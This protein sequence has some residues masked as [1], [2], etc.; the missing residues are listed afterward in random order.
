MNRKNSLL[1][2][3]CKIAKA[4]VWI[5][6]DKWVSKTFRGRQLQVLQRRVR[7]NPRCHCRNQWM[8]SRCD[9]DRQTDAFI[10]IPV[11]DMPLSVVWSVEGADYLA[12]TGSECN[13]MRRCGSVGGGALRFCE[14]PEATATARQTESCVG[15]KHDEQRGSV[16]LASLLVFLYFVVQATLMLRRFWTV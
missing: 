16:F 13:A 7:M 11:S 9:A 2:I 4:Y 15:E 10:D 12:Q 6:W 3:F 5:R 1:Q 8:I 14:C